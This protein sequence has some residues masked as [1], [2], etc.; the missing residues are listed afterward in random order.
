MQVLQLQVAMA[1]FQGQ[2]HQEY[3]HFVQLQL[4]DE[5]FDAGRKVMKAFPVD[6]GRS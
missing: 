6:A 1:V 2:M 4:N 5:P 3:G